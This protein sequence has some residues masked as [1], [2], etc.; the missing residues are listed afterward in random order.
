MNLLAS[1]VNSTGTN[2]T[3]V[4]FSAFNAGASKFKGEKC[5][6]CYV[7]VTDRNAIQPVRMGVAIVWQL[8]KLYGDAFKIDGVN[9]LFKSDKT[10]VAIKSAADPGALPA[11]WEADLA[12]FNAVRAKYLIY[13]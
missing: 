13:K 7:I 9:R 8:H 12:A 1:G 3:P 2:A 6:G 11:T 5:E 10:L 4:S